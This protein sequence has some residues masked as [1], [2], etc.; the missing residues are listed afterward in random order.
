MGPI[1]FISAG[2]IFGVACTGLG[3]LGLGLNS[4]RLATAGAAVSW[5]SVVVVTACAVL[6]GVAGTAQGLHVA[7]TY[8]AAADLSVVEATAL[9]HR[10]V[11][12]AVIPIV[13][14]CVPGALNIGLLGI[15]R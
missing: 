15:R 3:L 6:L 10:A 14:S 8:I 11:A 13:L 1:E 9:W 5:R 12:I 7:G 2:G 4:V